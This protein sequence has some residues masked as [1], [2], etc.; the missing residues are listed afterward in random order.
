MEKNIL[1]IDITRPTQI[2]TI[3][4]GISGSGKSTIAK[5]LVGNGIIHSTDTVLESMGDYKTICK[6]IDVN[7]A[8]LHRAHSTNLKNAVQ[9]IIDGI[10]PVVIDNTNLK[11]N[12]PKEYVVKALELGLSE[13]NIQIIDIGLNG[14]TAEELAERN[15]HGVSL[16][17]I[18]KMIQMYKSV[19][20]LSV[21]KILESK[22]KF[23]RSDVAYT[24]VE[25][26]EVSKNRLLEEF[27]CQIPE[28]W[29]IFANH[30]TIRLGEMKDK[31]TLGTNVVLVVTH[32]GFSDMAMAVKVD[33]EG[34]TKNKFPHITIA[35]NPDGGKPVMSNDIEKWQDV[36]KFNVLGTVKEIKRIV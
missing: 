19:G 6:E 3:M 34:E 20:P 31:S 23:P 12:D 21:K 22:D 9:S 1:N 16:D 29:V 30:M 36:K 17:V 32:L 11:M 25:L 8:P 24:C 2:L 26:Y 4:R 33:F 18:E 28:N 5:T 15:T 14:F 7:P 27:G 35:I 10:S 13:Q